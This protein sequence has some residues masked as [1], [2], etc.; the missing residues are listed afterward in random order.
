MQHHHDP[1]QFTGGD[2]A[3]AGPEPYDKVACH[4]GHGTPRAAAKGDAFEPRS[5]T[6]HV[7]IGGA[8]SGPTG[9][10]KQIA[11]GRSHDV[12]IHVHHVNPAHR[13][14]APAAPAGK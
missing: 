1:V 3:Y 2:F 13:L 5:P 8:Y 11:L 4:H 12:L 10:Y 7:S 14:S 9:P 6:G